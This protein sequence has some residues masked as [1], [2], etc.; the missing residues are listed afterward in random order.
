MRSTSK[1][2]ELQ[3]AGKPVPEDLKED[4]ALQ[5]GE[6]DVLRRERE[7]YEAQIAGIRARYDADKQRYS[8]LTAVAPR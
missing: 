5:K 4:I 3:K 7:R 8:E 6:V 2:A 1:R